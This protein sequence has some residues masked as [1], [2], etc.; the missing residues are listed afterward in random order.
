LL[1]EP[2]PQPHVPL[3]STLRGSDK[4]QFGCINEHGGIDDDVFVWSADLARQLFFF[5]PEDGDKNI[6]KS[7]RYEPG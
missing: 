7:D 5:S 1:Y 4:V 2:I 3:F 6:E